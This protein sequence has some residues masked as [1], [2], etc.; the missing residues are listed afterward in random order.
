[1]HIKGRLVVLYRYD[2]IV[3]QITFEELTFPK[4]K[5]VQLI[6]NNPKEEYD[7]TITN[8]GRRILY[9]YFLRSPIS[10]KLLSFM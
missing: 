4:K 1:M 6:Q 7:T 8:G 3:Q 5:M 9:I 2:E 10:E